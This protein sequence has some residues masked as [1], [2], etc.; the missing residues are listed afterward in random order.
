MALSIVIPAYNE[1]KI[2]GKVLEDIEE[3]ISQ[4][5]YD[6]E[7][8]VVD[9]ASEDKTAEIAR[10]K[11]VNV[12]QHAKN[13][14]YG[15][16]LKTGI[17]SARNDVIVMLDAD[18]SYPVDEMPL[19]LEDI[20]KHEMVIGART[21]KGSVKMS[22]LRRIPK[23]ALRKLAEYL[24]ME[25]IPDINSGFRVFKRSMYK[26]YVHILPSGFSFTLTLTLAS[27]VGDEEVKFVPVS[28]YKRKGISKIRPIYDTTNFFILIIRTIL[29]FNPLRV[30]LPMAAFLVFAALGIAA[31]SIYMGRLHDVTVTLLI[32]FG[33]QV[34]LLGLIAD[35][36]DRKTRTHE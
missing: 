5:G 29:Y 23:F 20:D 25:K 17:R 31:Y 9:D 3:I 27:I 8:I 7:I 19:L 32:I 18:G 36:I 1:E 22:L 13:R 26:K 33:I 11:G 16:A 24:A 35:L 15:A 28:Y 2:L 6:A 30:F 4:N 12:L 21:K 34:M 14:G 10:A